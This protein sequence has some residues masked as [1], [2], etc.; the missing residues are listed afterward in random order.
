MV[1]CGDR[2]G[3]GDVGE[4]GK[5]ESGKLLV[6]LWK[7][8]EYWKPLVSLLQNTFTAAWNSSLMIMDLIWPI[9]IFDNDNICDNW[10]I[11]LTWRGFV[12]W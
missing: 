4:G 2:T 7:P 8:G 5:Y 9:M 11:L 12:P 6:V 3:L 10:K 1:D